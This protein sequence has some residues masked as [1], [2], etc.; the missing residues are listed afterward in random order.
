MSP[1]RL[2]LFYFLS[3]DDSGE[4][5]YIAESDLYILWTDFIAE[6]DELVEMM[7]AKKENETK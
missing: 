7:K 4:I 3:T 1:N 5:R 6:I 2:Y